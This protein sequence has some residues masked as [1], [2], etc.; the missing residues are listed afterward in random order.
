MT[1]FISSVYYTLVTFGTFYI[2]KNLLIY[3]LIKK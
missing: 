1:I 3:Y 2:Q